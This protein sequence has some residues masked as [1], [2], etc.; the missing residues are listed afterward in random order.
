MYRQLHRICL[1]ILILSSMTMITPDR[2]ATAAGINLLQ[3]SSFEVGDTTPAGWTTQEWTQ[4]SDLFAWDGAVA[5]TGNRSVRI[6]AHDN[7]ARWLQVVAVEPHTLYRLSGY[8]RT[9]G[10]AQTQSSAGANLALEGTW[11]HSNGMFGDHDWTLVSLDFMTGN[12]QQVTVAARLG[13]WAGT[14]TGTAWFDDLRL[15]KLYTPGTA[16]INPDMEAGDTSPTVWASDPVEGSATFAWD[17]AQPH[18]GGRSLRVSV[19]GQGIAR[20]KQ[21]VM[22]QPD[23]EYELS[24]WIRTANIVDPAGQWWITGARIEIVG[25]DSYLSGASPG[26]R[27]TPDW[28]QVSVRFITGRTTQAWVNCEIGGADSLF[29]RSTSSGTMWCDDLSLTWLR[30][31]SRRSATGTHTGLDVY[32]DDFVFTNPDTYISLLDE[33]YVAMADLVGGTPYDGA[34]IIVRSD[35]NMNYGLLSGNPITIGPGRSWADI[36][37]QHGIDFGVPHELGHDFDLGPG[38]AYYMGNLTFDNAEHW[39][40]FKVLYAYEMLGATHPELTNSCYDVTIPVSQVGSCF[41]DHARQLWLPA[42]GR[43]YTTMGNDTYTGMLYGLRQEIGWE[44]F[45]CA[46]RTYARMGASPP[47]GSDIA[48]V[49][50][51]ADT[52]GRCAGRDLA[53]YFRTWGFPVENLHM[54]IYLPL[55]RR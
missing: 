45:K 25:A 17:S 23:S 46:F 19:D 22:V 1:L 49:Q 31:L 6:I 35:A 27:D 10:I 20:W 42:T 8:I 43:D 37:N 24:G 33:A 14:S 51:W 5:H 41:T 13:F 11:N 30:S 39:A 3:N 47:P 48:K 7:D 4:A 34:K 21:M 12:E 36:V 9:Q 2:S 53:P 40:N 44:P 38:P 15:E 55:I 28:T 16:I 32:Q 18:A 52:L 54:Q 26:Q 29:S 50:L